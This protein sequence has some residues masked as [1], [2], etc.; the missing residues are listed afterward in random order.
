[1]NEIDIIIRRLKEN[2]EVA[3]KFHRVESKI[4]TILNFTDLFEVLLTEIQNN[5][6]VPYVWISLVEDSEISC[7]IEALGSSDLLK[8]HLNVI[9]KQTFMELIDN[10]SEPVLLN[11]DLKPYFRLF[12]PNRKFFIKSM[13]VAPISLDGEII[14]SLN[15]ADSSA[16]RFQPGIDT[17]LLE[18][19][20]LKVSLCLSNVTAHEKLKFLAY[21]DPLTGLVNRR[22]MEKILKREFLRAKRYQTPL[23]LIFIDLDHFKY[24]NDTYGHESGDELLV[25]AADG[26][27][28][29]C[30][31]SDIVA[32]YAGDEFVFILPETG[33]I[34]AE[35]LAHRMALHFKNH[36]YPLHESDVSISI[37]CGIAST[38]G[39]TI[40]APEMLVKLA[41]ERLYQKKKKR[42]R[43]PEDTIT[44]KTNQKVI[45]FSAAFNEKKP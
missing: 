25:Y 35:N 6:K 38:E 34:S 39:D 36:P 19:L 31:Q 43:K 22:V 32:R 30:R 3:K 18:Q 1:M 13:A 15:Q 27:M 33:L 7:L 20:A 28:K 21:H 9:D 26:F 10:M 37:S 12:P 29:M 41:D 40:E 5:F 45:S 2:E 23:S 14:G 17:S 16:A 8:E 42:H 44:K 11:T 4:L 24:I